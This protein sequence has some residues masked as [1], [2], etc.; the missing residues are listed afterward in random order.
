MHTTSRT[1]HVSVGLFY[2]KWLRY[3]SHKTD[4]ACI[5]LATFYEVGGLRTPQTRFCMSPVG[6]LIRGGRAIHATELICLNQIG[7]FIRDWSRYVRH[8]LD[9][10]CFRL[11][12]LCEVVALCTP[13][14]GFCM[15]PVDYFIPSDSAMHVTN[16][17]LP[18]SGGFCMSVIFVRMLLTQ[19]K[20][21]TGKPNKFFHLFE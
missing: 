20:T 3:A 17:I 16:R 11:A 21:N 9:S 18:V 5:R 13:Q 7:Y 1:L 6:Y 15:A 8:R 19:A 4:F 2:I 10:A 14:I 12:I